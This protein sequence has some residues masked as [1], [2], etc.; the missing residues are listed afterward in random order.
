MKFLRS[1]CS[2]IVLLLLMT[3]FSQ[4]S[5][6][7]KLQ[8][9]APMVFE[10]VY[11]QKWVAG[12]EGGGSGINVF[13][14]VKEN[15]ETLDSIYFRDQVAKLEYNEQGQSMYIGRFLTD[16]NNKTDMI[17][18]TDMKEESRNRNLPL[19]QKLPFELLDNECVVSYSVGGKTLYYKI[20]GIE[21]KDPVHYPSAPGGNN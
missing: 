10:N 19:K 13:I 20:T 21:I 11:A 18:S 6:A 1:F 14:P 9:K 8:D 2:L 4:C 3:S 15:T 17:L 5:S 16:F 7:Q 12:V